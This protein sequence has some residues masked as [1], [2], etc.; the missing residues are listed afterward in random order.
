MDT[1]LEDAVR[2]CVKCQENHKLP[3]RALM[4]SWEWPDCPWA[5]LHA[6]YAGS[7]QEEMVLVIVGTHS[8]WMDALTVQSATSHS[9]IERLQSVLLPMDYRKS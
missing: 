1:E 6:D 2:R 8:K 3:P 7:I 9:T 4:H 5:R